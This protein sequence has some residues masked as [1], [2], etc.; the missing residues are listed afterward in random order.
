M[1]TLFR[2]LAILILAALPVLAQ[3]GPGPR[4]GR[5]MAKALNLSEVQQT[6]IQAIHEKHRPDLLARRDAV[7]QAQSALHAAL[8]DP[9]STEAQLRTL[10]EKAAS[11]RFDM[12]LA[13]R[14]V[15]QEVQA[16]LTP[17]QRAKAAEWQAA[18]QARRQERMRHLR[19]AMGMAG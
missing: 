19:M 8:Q 1:S 16:V 11:A 14:A 17:E 6:S 5:G 3:P 2:P 10:H 18:R 9:A 13:G 4:G 7:R 15:H 12:L